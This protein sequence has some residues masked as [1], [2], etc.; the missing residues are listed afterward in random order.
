MPKETGWA[1]KGTNGLYTGW[2]RRRRDAIE[3]H[4]SDKVISGASKNP[5]KDIWKRCQKDGDS[6]VKVTISYK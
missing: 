4:V 3:A 2:W 1:I 6:A 5:M